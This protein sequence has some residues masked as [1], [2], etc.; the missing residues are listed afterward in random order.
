MLIYVY[1]SQLTTNVEC[2]TLVFYHFEDSEE[3]TFPQF[4]YK[5]T[6]LRNLVLSSC[7]L[8]PFGTVNWS[9]LISLSLEDV[10]LT[11][12]SMKKILTGCP[13]LEC[14]ELKTFYG[15]NLTIEDYRDNKNGPWLEI[16]AP[17]IQKLQLLGYCGERRIRQRNVASLV[18]I[19][20]KAVFRLYIDH[21]DE[22]YNLEDFYNEEQQNLEKECRYLKELLHGVAHVENLEL[23][24]GCIQDLVARFV[25]EDEQSR[26][27]E[28]HNFDCS[29]RHLKTINIIYFHGAPSENKYILPLKKYLL[30]IVTVLEKVTIDFVKMKQEFLSFPRSSPHVS[31]VFSHV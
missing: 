29:L 17:H 5:N 26:R 21:D 31:V 7:Q 1:I 2:F 20:I 16:F 28:T 10:K 18:T 6:L 23:G 3:Y 14:L 15:I 27:F 4:A 24:T 30:K 19:V 8:N 13:N 12:G 25:D 11:H 22:E 9:N